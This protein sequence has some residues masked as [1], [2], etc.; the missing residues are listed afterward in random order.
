MLLILHKNKKIMIGVILILLAIVLYGLLHDISKLAV[1][2][3]IPNNSKVIIFYKKIQFLFYIKFSNYCIYKLVKNYVIDALWY[4]SFCLILFEIEHGKKKYV[5]VSLI[6]ILSEILQFLN[7]GL[8]TFDF[9]DLL[10]YGLV[11]LVFILQDI[12]KLYN[13]KI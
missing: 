2:S 8:G 13:R 9:F 7:H 3:F 12:K 6:G 5:I 11:L 10:I 1:F 4:S